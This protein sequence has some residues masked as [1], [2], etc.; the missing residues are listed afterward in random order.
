MSQF[1]APTC[2]PA[3]LIF[4]VVVFLGALGRPALADAQSVRGLIAEKCISCHQVPGF[5]EDRRS[6]TLNAPAFIDIANRPDIYADERL[7]TFLARPHF[8]MRQFTLSRRDIDNIIA[9][10]YSLRSVTQP[11]NSPSQ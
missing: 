2:S 11:T 3:V 8:P 9:F 1:Q 10:I 7:R 6:Q 5:P 4:F